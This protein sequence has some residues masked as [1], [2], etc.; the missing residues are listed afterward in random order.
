MLL[1]DVAPVKDSVFFSHRQ[2]FVALPRV[3][4]VSEYFDNISP[5]SLWFCNCWDEHA[6]AVW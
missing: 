3:S 5:T 2:N 6:F 1:L 4:D